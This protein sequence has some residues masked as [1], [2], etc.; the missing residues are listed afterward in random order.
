[1]GRFEE[2]I[3]EGKRAQALDPVSP[4]ASALLG[5][6]YYLARQYDHAIEE[7]RRALDLDPNFL[8]AHWLL[9]LAYA[10]KSMF[11][12]AIAESRKAIELSGHGPGAV[13]RLGNVYAT[14]GRRDEAQQVIVELKE[15]AKRRYVS[16]Y[17]V[18]AIYARLGDK[19]AA[20]E[21]LEKA[22]RDGAYGILFLKS[23]PEWDGFRSEP[24]FQDVMRRVGL[25]Q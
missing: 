16:P 23:A 22:Y 20:L 5:F 12:Q 11:E 9:G 4:R 17:S 25:P 10:N 18:A 8:F 19:E 6:D 7:C 24:R 2:S 13:G 14:A 1:M 3:A 15:L 21:W